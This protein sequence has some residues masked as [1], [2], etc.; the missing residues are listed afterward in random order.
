MLITASTY[1]GC[2]TIMDSWNDALTNEQKLE[3]ICN[4]SQVI[5]KNATLMVLKE[6]PQVVEPLLITVS[7]IQ[8]LFNTSDL[9]PSVIKDKV[10]K[11]LTEKQYSSEVI[12]AVEGVIGTALELY[13]IVYKTNIESNYDELSKSYIKI[14]A[15]VCNG[16]TEACNNSV[17]ASAN[18]VEYKPISEYTI[19]EL[20]FRKE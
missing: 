16:I 10:T 8:V 17:V 4:T 7:S 5:T 12:T 9:A 6:K 13:D 3:Q 11:V 2:S 19:E 15:S 18:V 20:T 1:C 14:L